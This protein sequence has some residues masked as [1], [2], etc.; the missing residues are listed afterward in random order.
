MKYKTIEKIYP[1]LDTIRSISFNVQIALLKNKNL[2]REFYD[3]I[4][5]IRKRVMPNGYAEYYM[6]LKNLYDKY[7]DETSDNMYTPK[8]G[9][10]EQFEKEFHIL[11][12]SNKDMLETFSRNEVIYKEFLQEDVQISFYKYSL[13]DLPDNLS[14]FEKEEIDLLFEFINN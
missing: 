13:D 7:C 2:L 11:L 3:L 8:E 5:D 4:Q 10:K 12:E 14:E 9:M 6:N 1:K